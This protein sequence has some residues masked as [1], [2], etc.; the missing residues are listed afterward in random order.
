MCGVPFNLKFHPTTPGHL[1][2]RSCGRYVVLRVSA[3]PSAPTACGSGPRCVVAAPGPPRAPATTP[4]RRPRRGRALSPPRWP[5]V[6]A[7]TGPCQRGPTATAGLPPVG[8]E[9]QHP[10]PPAEVFLEYSVRAAC[11]LPGLR[12]GCC[13]S[14]MCCMCYMCY[15]C[16]VR[17]VCVVCVS[18]VLSGSARRTARVLRACCMCCWCSSLF[19]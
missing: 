4:Q 11:S 1:F 19:V 16:C 12:V 6:W 9:L 3:G 15:M 10:P 2:V 18:R 5:P 13:M 8:R 17:C 14:L 7:G